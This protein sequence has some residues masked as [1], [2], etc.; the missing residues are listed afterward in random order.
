[1]DKFNKLIESILVE[2]YTDGSDLDHFRSN[3]SNTK[4]YKTYDMKGFNIGSYKYED[5]Y[6][7]SEVKPAYATKLGK[8]IL[9]QVESTKKISIGALG[10]D[11]SEV[12]ILKRNI[13][14]GNLNKEYE[15]ASIKVGKTEIEYG[16]KTP[17]NRYMFVSL[18]RNTN[19]ITSVNNY[20]KI[21][22]YD[23]YEQI[24]FK[25]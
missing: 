6:L 22:G 5:H 11:D 12:A 16:F 24:F 20:S 9:K 8:S 4:S 13:G 25:K 18:D 3:L 7:G 14:N 17:Y 15:I 1:M 23:E 19:K 10:G 2:E 21:D